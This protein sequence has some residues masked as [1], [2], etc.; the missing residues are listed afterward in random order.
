MLPMMQKLYLTLTL[1]LS[2]LLCSNIKAQENNPL[3]LPDDPR[4]KTGQLANGLTYYIMKNPAVKGHADFA[5]GQ[6]IGTVLENGNQ[7]GMSRMLELLATRGTRN[8]TDSTIMV[9]LNTLG[10]G[11]KDIS[12]E[13]G[14]DEI[15]YTIENV[16]IARQNT[17]DST[18]LV[19]YNWMSSINIDEED[20]AKAMPMLKNTLIEKWDAKERINGM[21]IKKLY[22][23]S[24]YAKA[25]TPEQINGLDPY[26]SKE[27]RNFYYK[28][29]R[30][31]LQSVFVVGDIDPAKIETQ[32]KSIFATIPKPLKAEKRNY[33]TPKLIKGTE[34]VISKDPEYDKT[35]VSINFQ[36]KPL[37]KEYKLTSIPYI[38][39]YF[40]YA[41]ST[42][43]YG[44]IQSGIVS[45]NL[46][47]TNVRIEN[48]K[49][50]GMSNMETFTISFETLHGSLYPA[51]AFMSGEINILATNGFGN[52]EFISSKDNYFAELDILYEN[53]FSQPNSL[54]MKRLKDNYFKGSSLAS[55]EMHFTLMKDILYGT[56]EANG[57]RL[58]DLNAYASALLGQKEGVA[59]L[60][61]MPQ[62][63]GID[64]PSVERI[65]AAFVNTLSKSDYTNLKKEK[66]EWP[67]FPMGEHNASII[68][69]N[70]DP[71]SGV[72]M[73]NL[74]NGMN[75][76]FKQT[77]GS[78]D[79][80]SFRAVSKGG[81]SVANTD[82]ERDISLY[83]SDIAN[84]S[85]VGGF[86]KTTWDKLFLYN[87]MALHVGIND[88][89]EEL[90]GFSKIENMEKFFHLI[91]MNFTQRENDYNS[92]DIYK[93]GKSYEALYRKL[94]PLKV[95]EDSVQYYGHSNKRFIPT[96]SKEYVDG[97]DYYK[98]QQIINGRLANPADFLFIFAGNADI[99]KIREYIVK[100]LSVLPTEHDS[101]EWFTVPDY[102][103]K[104]R[105]SRRF[106]HQMVIPQTYLN[107]TLSCGMPV[108]QQ[109][110]ILAGLL[111]GFLKKECSMGALKELSPK[112]NIST[113]LKYYPEEI[114][115]CQMNFVTDSAGA[116]QIID[117]VNSKLEKIAYE[118]MAVDE[119][120]ALVSTFKQGEKTAQ[121]KNSYWINALA[122]R[123][124]LGKDIITGYSTAISSVTPEM[125][126]EFVDKVY[127][128]GNAISVIMEGT[129][130]D[131]NTQNLFREN[132]FIRDFFDL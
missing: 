28:W 32:I 106:L 21:H 71:L 54:F 84:L 14:E 100:Y 48:G 95:F 41:V 104:G 90:Y 107:L 3:P 51:I 129:T 61:S 63:G 76:A 123:Y 80:L 132:Q 114:M 92:F 23:R 7:K 43:L 37:T 131:V 4:I 94:S 22:P 36:R 83:I 77:S 1:S 46:P 52:Q 116:Q 34:V 18:L 68:A 130:Q 30:P 65:Q 53:R 86:S 47:I 101:E 60:C 126:K 58:K 109:N 69:E 74:S 79:T 82:L 87:N 98:I 16:P 110:A 19:L 93:R 119:F 85:A 27:L 33:Y 122:G 57:I 2:I 31:D 128:R 38:Q 10:L 127:R 111:N 13:T 75:V 67:R 81:L 97:M 78:L 105:V 11:S 117:I 88:H 62:V 96:H 8:F 73:F 40:D 6:K 121:A 59:I 26:S 102:A 113:D 15:V 9:Y 115:T 120:N 125:F 20:I 39:A 89:M 91:N 25:I 44:R 50:L 103:T 118:G 70:Y 108:T 72:T 45:Q 24:P 64:N 66:I 49:F 17:I 12:F 56:N 99:E 42:L 55:I 5:V 124:L 29:F 112:S 35:T